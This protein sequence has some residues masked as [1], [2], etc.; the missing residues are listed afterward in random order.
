MIQYVDEQYTAVYNGRSKIRSVCSPNHRRGR[1]GGVQE[2]AVMA[3]GI[4]GREE[5]VLDGA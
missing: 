5:T 2:L 4:Q 3:E 1:G